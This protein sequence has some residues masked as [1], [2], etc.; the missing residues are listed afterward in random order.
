[1]SFRLSQVDIEYFR[2]ATNPCSI[3]FDTSKPLVLVF[4]E[5]GTGKSTVVDAFD[6]IANG[7]IGTIRD[8]S[9]ATNKHA[10]AI[11]RK[12]TDIKVL[13][14]RGADKWAGS[15]KGSTINVSPLANRPTIE[16]L[17]RKQ[18]LSFVEAVPGKRYEILQRF[19]D[20][21]GVEQS[22]RAALDALN[23]VRQENSEAIRKKLA[24]ET[25]LSE[26]W[27]ANGRP[28]KSWREWAATK[29][30]LSTTSLDADVSSI[31]DLLEQIGTFRSR[32]LD[33]D[34]AAT[35]AQNASE[36]LANVESELK[37][38]ETG[39]S[40]Q[41]PSLILTLNAAKSLLDAGW[42]DH[43]CPVC[44]QDIQSQDL[45]NRVSE[46]LASLTT[47]KAVYDRHQ[48]ASKV[49]SRAADRVNTERLQLTQAALSLIEVAVKNERQEITALNLP[50]LEVVA[51]LTQEKLSTEEF[52]NCLD[53][54]KQ[55]TSLQESLTST[56]DERSRDSN[57]LHTIKTEFQN[58]VDADAESLETDTLAK[59]LEQVHDVVR[60]QRIEYVQEV[61]DSVAGEV[62]RLYLTIH[63]DEDTKAGGLKLDPKKRASLN[64]F[65][66]FA[67]QSDIEPQGYFSDSHL[68]TLGFCYWLALAKRERPDSKVVV[69]D[70]VFT[71]VDAPHLMRIIELIDYE[72]DCFAQMFVITHN[73]NWRNQYS[74]NRAAGG[75]AHLIELR[76]WNAVRGITHDR[77]E[78]EIDKLQK[79]LDQ[80]K[81]AK[82]A[83]ARQEICNQAGVLL[84]AIFDQLSSQYRCSIPRSADGNYALADL[85]NSCTKLMKSLQVQHEADP[86]A[87]DQQQ[88]QPLP[89]QNEFNAVK[90]TAFIRNLVGCHYNE[91]GAELT[92]VEIEQFGKSAVIMARAV[93]CP[94]CGEI[95]RSD[96]NTHRQCS[97]KHTRLIPSRI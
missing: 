67:G 50:L 30:N 3:Q 64:Q 76:R 10:P 23:N 91:A 7:E 86:E 27:E 89:V 33:Y 70:D 20:V 74:F 65:A 6:L 52:D 54:C 77:T 11:G 26:L 80:A 22:E 21:R 35:A 32:L 19:I 29:V 85:I 96:K 34:A 37:K 49:V 93:I 46:N 25:A 62:S 60:Q 84:E 45:R 40:S 90:E 41:T 48:A 18:L 15:L 16:I 36:E 68:D 78:L 44:S 39:W 17:R 28:N 72:C 75:K 81:Q 8:R 69:L 73:R 24:A 12:A 88:A 87:K 47:A 95:P 1:M 56:R 83:V 55:L 53:T 79:L 13:L 14:H 57:Q 94:K 5:N 58:A 66:E 42:T 59:L 82:T 4:G 9:S 92:D 2:G 97:C 61:L 63:P 38:L 71:S 31:N 43:A 51:T